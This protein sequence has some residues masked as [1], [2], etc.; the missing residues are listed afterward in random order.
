MNKIRF[1]NTQEIQA[2]AAGEVIERPASIVKELLEN[3]LD[4]GATIIEIGIK[5]G[6]K[7][8]IEIYDNGHGMNKYDLERAIMPHAT[9]KL[10]FDASNN[11]CVNTYGFRGEALAT[12]G[13]IS[14]IT[15]QTREK[16]SDTGYQISCYESN[17][18]H[19]ESIGC[20][21]GTKITIESIFN[22]VPARKKFLK[23]RE[24]EWHAIESIII[25]NAF[26][27]THIHFVVKHDNKIIYNIPPAA[28]IANRVLQITSAQHKQWLVPCVYK[29]ENISVEGM[30][31]G[32]EYGCYDRSNIFTVINNRYIKQNKITQCVTKP[33]QSE[34]FVK[35][36]PVAY[37]S[38]KIDPA[39]VDINV[40]PRKEEVAFLH[41]K[42][43]EQSII[44]AIT[45]TLEQ[46]T[47]KIF[48]LAN[49]FTPASLITNFNNCDDFLT[50]K[51]V[52]TNDITKL[53]TE[54]SDKEEVMF[55][56]GCDEDEVV[57]QLKNQKSACY[58]PLAV[59]A[60]S[61]E[62]LDIKK[63]YGAEEN[64]Y[65]TNTYMY[66]QKTFINSTHK[67]NMIVYCG[68]FA[69]TY[70]ICCEEEN[71]IL[72]D[73]HALHERIMYEKLLKEAEDTQL[74][75]LLITPACFVRSSQI[76]QKIENNKK[77]FEMCGIDIDIL[78]TTTFLVR[79]VNGI[80]KKIGIEIACDEII[81]QIDTEDNYETQQD[82]VAIKKNLICNIIA[83]IACKAA[84][85]AG[86]ILCENDI[87][88]LIKQ[89][90][91]YKEVSLCPH[92]RPTYYVFSKNS[93]DVLFK[94]K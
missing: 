54:L 25:A 1:L 31:S 15:I 46:R 62:N 7:D 19:I 41:P 33:Y 68:T 93:I 30:I 91:L 45:E 67:Q 78:N 64:L 66:E 88:E 11:I 40:H 42:K 3:A 23:T 57:V 44:K 72:I 22:P 27:H 73:Q 74:I 20:D 71:L 60:V 85:K 89:V 81:A 43:I 90:H 92:G 83:N 9:S 17:I 49:A 48:D 55:D 79:G 6:G 77:I 82:I 47:K 58:S 34:N 21:Y 37:L 36:Y 86:Q 13:A 63:S 18:S 16:T 12:I 84:V 39:L 61:N 87:Q 4:S 69:Q 94:R 65:D 75:N 52:T 53:I 76:I 35:R 50:E 32:I 24:T 14:K 51:I 8:Y 29:D 70:L 28:S 2:I 80:I 38:I 56:S 10:I 5:N 26:I 59:D